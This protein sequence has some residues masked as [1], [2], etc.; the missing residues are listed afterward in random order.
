MEEN[1][2]L[3]PLISKTMEFTKKLLYKCCKESH[4]ASDA[5]IGVAQSSKFKT[6]C[7]R[8]RINDEMRTLRFR[9]KWFIMMNHI[10]LKNFAYFN[11]INFIQM[12]LENIK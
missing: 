3:P 12:V 9:K 2:S 11:L 10:L 5:Q 7:F 1:G 6:L 4:D 8:I